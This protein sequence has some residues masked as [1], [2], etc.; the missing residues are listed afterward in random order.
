MLFAAVHEFVIGTKRTCAC[1]VHMSAF[2]GKVD[3]NAGC[4][5]RAPH[6]TVAGSYSRQAGGGRV[7]NPNPQSRDRP[8]NRTLEKWSKTLGGN[9]LWRRNRA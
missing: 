1:A 7:R 6:P 4:S 2:G 3:I 5:M 9:S 8:P